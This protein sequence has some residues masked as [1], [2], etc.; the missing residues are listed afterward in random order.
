MTNQYDI[1]V[2]AGE[3]REGILPPGLNTAVPATDIRADET[4]DSYNISLSHDNRIA[5]GSVPSG[6][7]RIA[8]TNTVSAV[9]YIWHFRRLWRSSGTDLIYGAPDYDDFYI[10]QKLGKVPF[11][12][13]AN[14]I[15]AF[16]PFGDGNIFVAKTSGSYILSNCL[17]SRALFLKS[18]IMQEMR[19]PTAGQIVE[20]DEAVYVSNASGVWAYANGK[21]VEITRNVRNDVT[22]YANKQLTA[23]YQKKYI[24]GGTDFVFEPATEKLFNYQA[25]GFRFTS[26]QLHMPDW[27]PFAVDRLVFTIEHSD[28]QDGELSY[29]WRVDDG[30]WS[31]TFQVIL[32]YD[33]ERYTVVTEGLD[34]MRSACRFQMR[35]TALSSTKYIRNIRVDSS[36]FNF[37][38]YRA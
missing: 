22:K 27:R 5:V 35:L 6:T 8:K 37:D 7:T 15:V 13:D 33:E 28:T 24:I 14:P 4:P 23:D 25:S 11:D 20:L 10:P 32:P 26:R 34:N 1:T 12:E 30:E 29:Q 9:N 36:T 18:D 21:V 17:D 31:D 38:D 19:C 16:L 2:L 3:T